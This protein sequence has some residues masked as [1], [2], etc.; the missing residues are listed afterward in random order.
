VDMDPS[1]VHSL[2]RVGVEFTMDLWEA[3]KRQI[4]VG[5]HDSAITLQ[6]S[7]RPGLCCGRLLL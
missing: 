3:R 4:D 6:P 2:A 7:T 5:G 1:G